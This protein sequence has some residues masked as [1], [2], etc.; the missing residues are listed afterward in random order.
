M[1]RTARVRI[2]NETLRRCLGFPPNAE[3]LSVKTVDPATSEMLVCCDE[4]PDNAEPPLLR[5]PELLRAW[6]F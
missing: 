3:I 5:S 4:F 2:T 1:A 6:G